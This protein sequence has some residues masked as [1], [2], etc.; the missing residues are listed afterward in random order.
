M[1]FQDF[2][3]KAYGL[4]VTQTDDEELA[5]FG[6]LEGDVKKINL[7]DLTLKSEQSLHEGKEPRS[8]FIGAI[9]ECTYYSSNHKKELNF[10]SNEQAT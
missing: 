5:L 7:G 10:F 8:S 9:N 6:N 4:D 1:I 3:K 2:G